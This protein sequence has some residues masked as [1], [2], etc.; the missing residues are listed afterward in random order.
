MSD[1]IIAKIKDTFQQLRKT[2][3]ESKQ[4]FVSEA[5]FQHMFAIALA[6]TFGETAKIIPEFP[7]IIKGRTIYI[8]IM[9]VTGDGLYPIELKYKTKKL[10]S[11]MP[12][13]NTGIKVCDI[14]KNHSAQDQN[15]YECWKDIHRLEQLVKTGIAQAGLAI[16]ISND[17]YYWEGDCKASSQGYAFRM[18]PG[19]YPTG[20]KKWN[21]VPGREPAKWLKQCPEFVIE[22]DYDFVWHD[23]YVFPANNGLF[24]SLIIEIPS[25]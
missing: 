5:H 7:V 3:S 2:V 17:Q 24:R 12:Y 6:K 1:K 25:K 4:F 16:V 22:N 11:K 20:K 23:F 9:V 14:L 13:I 8:D 21:I 10:D 19:T 18:L 15:G